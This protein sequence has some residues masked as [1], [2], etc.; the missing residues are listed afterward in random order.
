LSDHFPLLSSLS[1]QLKVREDDGDDGDD[2][3]DDE[4]NGQMI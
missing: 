3:D 2:G 1:K 4:L